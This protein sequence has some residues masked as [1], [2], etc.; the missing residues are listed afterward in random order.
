MIGN[1]QI[2]RIYKQLLKKII[3][4][5]H[6]KYM[7]TYIIIHKKIMHHILY[8]SI[9]QQQNH[10]IRFQHCVYLIYILLCNIILIDKTM[11]YIIIMYYNI[12]LI[13]KTVKPKLFLDLLLQI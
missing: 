11:Y 7:Y 6:N 13:D 3:I 12:I 8:V 10:T 1:I 9:V 2:M 5:Y 4:E